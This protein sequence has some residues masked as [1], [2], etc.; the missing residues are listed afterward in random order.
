MI[1]EDINMDIIKIDSA[2]CGLILLT[3]HNCYYHIV[4]PAKSFSGLDVL[5][6][7]DLLLLSGLYV[8]VGVDIMAGVNLLSVVDTTA[9]VY[10]VNMVIVFVMELVL[11]EVEVV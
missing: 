11:L 1:V 6:G 4:I 2:C 8:L 10:E 7:V 5:V 3:E 9:S